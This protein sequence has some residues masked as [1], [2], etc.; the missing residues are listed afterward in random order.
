MFYES[1][2]IPVLIAWQLVST[3][4]WIRPVLLLMKSADCL[5][6]ATRENILKYFFTI[7]ALTKI[8]Q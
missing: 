6:G 1:V 7:S 8:L 5:K 3:R 2:P 4:I